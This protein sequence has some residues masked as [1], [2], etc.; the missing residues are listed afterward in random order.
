MEKNILMKTTLQNQ[1][2]HEHKAWGRS[3][4]FFRQEN[5]LLKYRLSEIVDYNED[6]EF[7]QMAEYFQNELLLKDDLLN[8]LIKDLQEFFD[9]FNA[10]PN[11]K[12]LP[13]KII[14]RQDKLRNDILQFENNFLHLSKEFNERMLQ[15]I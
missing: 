12:T 15:S 2:K 10:L 14:T 5:A 9:Q 8:K 1:F 4:E 7:L 3:L 13:Q 6:N 11:E